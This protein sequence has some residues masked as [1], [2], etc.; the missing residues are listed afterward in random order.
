MQIPLMGCMELRVT[1]LV[2]LL[3]GPWSPWS[4]LQL[5]EEVGTV[6]R[7]G[8]WVPLPLPSHITPTDNRGLVKD[9][10]DP[11]KIV[12]GTGTVFSIYACSGSEVI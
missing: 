1:W 6:Y 3:V 5:Q 7:Q 10:V 4:L 9:T 12:T 2:E 11:L 8:G